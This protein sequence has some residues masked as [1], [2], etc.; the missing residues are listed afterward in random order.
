MRLVLAAVLMFSA[1]C[2]LSNNSS[3]YVGEEDRYIKS[4]SKEDVDGY[5]LGKGMGFAKAAELNGYPGPRHV[6]DLSKELNL[7]SMQI[8]KSNALFVA[9]QSE[10]AKLGASLIQKEGELERLFSSGSIDEKKLEDS[11]ISISNIKGKIRL[12][13]LAAHIEQ[14]KVLTANQ[15][16]LYIK[17]R[18]Y[19]S[20]HH[21]HDKNSHHH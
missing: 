3:P 18:G 6:L 16:L 14:K 1:P 20:S 11:L 2:C 19:S 5:L 17:H 9:M 13:H 15:V 12:S 10:A 8:S 4:L 7:T 21:G